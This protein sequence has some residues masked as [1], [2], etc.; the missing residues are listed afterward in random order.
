MGNYLGLPL[1]MLAAALQVSFIPQIRILGGE[2]DLTFL[3]VLSWAINAR[4]EEGVTWAVVG[5]IM[6]DLVTA[7]PTGASIPGMVILVFAVDRLKQ[8]VF[9]IGLV[10]LVALVVGG[11]ILQKLIYMLVNTFAG[12]QIR[13]LDMLSYVILPTVAYNLVVIWPIYWFVRRFLR[14][15]VEPRRIE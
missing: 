13:P 2:P 7:A 8:Q 10:A 4:L 15:P 3:F 5:A 14:A 1:L 11:T 6:R 9:G 12:F